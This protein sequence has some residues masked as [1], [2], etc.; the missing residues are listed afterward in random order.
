MI[1]WRDVASYLAL[2]GLVISIVTAYLKL[3]KLWSRRHS[4]EVTQSISV[5]AYGLDLVVYFCYGVNFYVLGVTHGTADAVLWFVYASVILLIGTGLWVRGGRKLSFW[6]RAKQALLLEKGEVGNLVNS[7]IHPSHLE[8]IFEI[9]RGFAAIDGHISPDEHRLLVSF[10]ERWGIPYE[11]TSSSNSGVVSMQ[12][13]VKAVEQYLD[14]APGAEQVGELMDLI[15][16]VIRADDVESDEERMLRNEI[17]GMFAAYNADNDIDHRYRVILAPQNADQERAIIDLLDT[18]TRLEIAGGFG[19]LVDAFYSKEYATMVRD[20][21]R[22]L[23][24]FTVDVDN[25]IT[26]TTAVG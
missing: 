3:N 9:L 7:I 19:F 18:P 24:F 26:G 16:A 5:S 21:Y 10:A 25:Q 23:G 12:R 15:N 17:R 22:R 11:R 2:V 14:L 6:S 13:I 4:S 20:Q 8:E 1:E